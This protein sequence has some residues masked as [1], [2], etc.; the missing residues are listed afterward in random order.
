MLLLSFV[1]TKQSL[2]TTLMGANEARELLP[3]RLRDT[4]WRRVMTLTDW[5]NT[6]CCVR[7]GPRAFLQCTH[8]GSKERLLW[9][10]SW[11]H[12]KH[13]QP[14]WMV[15]LYLFLCSA[16]SARAKPLSTTCVSVCWPSWSLA[17]PRLCSRYPGTDPRTPESRRTW[18]GTAWALRAAPERRSAST[19][20]MRSTSY[21]D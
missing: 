6:W 1:R 18:R 3:W 9:Q 10:R 5:R 21:C 15:T 19:T 4:S 11:S 13:H 12:V 17:T 20:R 16:S 2:H 8:A 14:L 7:A